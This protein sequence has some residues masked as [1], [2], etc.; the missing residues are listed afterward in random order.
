MVWKKVIAFVFGVLV[1]ASSVPLIKAQSTQTNSLNLIILVSDNEADYTL[2][3]KLA[4]SLNVSVVVTP[5]GI[6]NPNVTAE[7]V[8]ASPDEVLIIGGPA[9]VP[10]AY[11]E[12]LDEVGISYA[13]LWGKNRFETNIA[14]L[15]YII[16]NYPDLLENVKIVIAHGNDFGAIK[17]VKISKMVIPVY[18]NDDNTEEQIKILAV[19]KVSHVIIIKTPLSEN[20]TKEVEVEIEK[21]IKA[22]ITEDMANITAD[23]A[24]EA[25][26]IAENKTM[27]AKTLVDEIDIPSAERL[28]DLAEE[29]L[30]EAK[31]AYDE[32]K[33]G[34][35]Y[36]LAT[37]AKSH[38]E[39]VIRFANEHVEKVLK[40]N[41]TAKIE[42]QLE[43]LEEIID[44]MEEFG[45]NVTV[46]K[47]L[48][49]KAEEAYESGDYQTALQTL[50]ELKDIIK[51]RLHKE[52]LTLRMKWKEKKEYEEMEKH[53]KGREHMEENK[54]GEKEDEEDEDE[55][56]EE[57]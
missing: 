52:K 29:K 51:E 49:E 5:W 27:L 12:D 54:H 48:L 36:G 53:K 2:A 15:Q 18:V 8:T 13:R 31:E 43:K 45:L 21:E 33:Y 46:E 7:L 24:W 47:A 19:I 34:R 35:A 56:N 39:I 25:I 10:K 9:A 4:E 41:Q 17:K 11:E 22:N 3:E 37:A 6:Y 42:I 44:T 20:V 28:L 14:V 30:E 26:E 57:S 23:V 55:E 32:G 50:D 1:L 16:E 40:T 38:A